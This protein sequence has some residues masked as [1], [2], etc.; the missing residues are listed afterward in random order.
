MLII[1]CQRSGDELQ[2]LYRLFA[3]VVKDQPRIMGIVQP[4]WYHIWASMQRLNAEGKRIVDD[5][6]LES[7][8]TLGKLLHITSEGCRK[9]VVQY[10]CAIKGGCNWYRCPLHLVE[11]FGML[12]IEMF[13]CMGC[14][15]VGAHL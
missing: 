5:D 10:R 3:R 8:R 6:G 13:R 9:E 11:D 12:A 1:H 4:E 14:E 2:A 7:W 15:A